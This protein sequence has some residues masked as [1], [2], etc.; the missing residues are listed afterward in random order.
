MLYS[1]FERFCDTNRTKIGFI[2]V[3]LMILI[4][5]IYFDETSDI[6]WSG[7]VGMLGG[8]FV[9]STVIFIIS[10]VL[11]MVDKRNR[12]KERGDDQDDD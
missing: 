1:R 6:V 11:I 8:W 2:V 4:G 7:V 5:K 9:C 12:K 10:I 3:T